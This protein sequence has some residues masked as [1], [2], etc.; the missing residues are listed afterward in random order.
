VAT[1]HLSR[2]TSAT[3]PLCS[4]DAREQCPVLRR[5]KFQSLFQLHSRYTSVCQHC[6]IA[7]NMLGRSGWSPTPFFVRYVC[8]N[9]SELPT[10]LQHDALP[11]HR[12]RWPS[13]AHGEFPRADCLLPRKMKYSSHFFLC[14]L[15][16]YCRHC[17]P[18]AV[19]A[20]FVCASELACRLVAGRTYE[21][22][23]GQ[24]ALWATL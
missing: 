6:C 17:S 24:G 23:T 11:L 1:R 3:E 19:Q 21:H 9:V 8:P 16:Q 14:P 10:P 15:V 13:Q 20:C 22:M 5:V 18:D 2:Q 4:L 12:D 7:V